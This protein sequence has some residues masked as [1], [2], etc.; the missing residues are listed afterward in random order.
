MSS[1]GKPSSFSGPTRFNT[2]K[3]PSESNLKKAKFLKKKGIDNE[4]DEV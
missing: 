4:K 3:G 1:D 2:S